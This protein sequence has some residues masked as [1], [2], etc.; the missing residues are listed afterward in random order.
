[1]IMV[2]NLVCAIIRKHYEKIVNHVNPEQLLVQLESRGL[3]TAE[4]QYMLLN[5]NFS[6]QKRTKLLLLHLHSK[7]PNNA[8]LLF[9]ECLRAENEHSGHQYLADLLESDVRAFENQHQIPNSRGASNSNAAGM[10]GSEIDNILPTLTFYWMQVA[11][12]LDAPQEMISDITSSSQ[13]PEEQARMFLQRYTL[14]S[15]KGNIY[16]AL[17]QLGTKT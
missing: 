6:P 7:N 4:E 1:M 17:Q 11:E 15:R 2:F 3:V 13:D 14:Y 8:I 12:M 10:T 9:H 16:R 5:T